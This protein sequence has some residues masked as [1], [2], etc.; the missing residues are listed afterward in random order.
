MGCGMG[1]VKASSK[2]L[3]GLCYGND[4]FLSQF[5]Y[6]DVSKASVPETHESRSSAHSCGYAPIQPSCVPR[7]LAASERET[8]SLG[9]A[10]IPL[11]DIIPVY[12]KSL[13]SVVSNVLYECGYMVTDLSQRMIDH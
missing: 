11:V 1:S 5:A 13:E 10:I 12:L 7:C 6:P 8:R 9:G 3:E 2:P 4:L